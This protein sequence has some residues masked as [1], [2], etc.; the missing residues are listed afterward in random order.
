MG[1]V[2][3]P[4]GSGFAVGLLTQ[5]EIKGWCVRA[6]LTRRSPQAHS[7]S[8]QAALRSMRAFVS[9]LVSLQPRDSCPTI[10]G[11]SATHCLQCQHQ[12]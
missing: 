2:A 12:Q 11:D 7:L 3:L 5:S 10:L 8:Q 1:A 4:L 9:V 6:A